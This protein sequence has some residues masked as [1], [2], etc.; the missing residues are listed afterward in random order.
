M[1][2]M[3]RVYTLREKS[4]LRTRLEER[5]QERER[6][7]RELHDTLLQSIQGMMLSFQA[8]AESLPGGSRARDSME[9]ALDRAEQVIAE[10]RDRIT[11][12]RGQMAPTEDLATA[13]QALKLEAGVPFSA[14]Y[15]VSNVGEPLVL[16]NDVR[17]AFYQVGKEA[18]FN[19]LR[20][21]EATDI[22]VTF[23]YKPDRFEMLVVDNGIGIDPL[24]QRMHGRPEHGGLRGMYERADRI[25]ASLTMVSTPQ[26]GTRITLTLPGS[27]AYINSVAGK[28][29]RSSKTG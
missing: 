4:I 2:W 27:A 23:T 9:R 6:I 24:Y 7:A 25:D 28:Q 18:V 10:G 1:V 3:S 16:L 26:E 5:F 21:A 22:T 17:D 19:S 12:L 13:F 15:Q 20:H 14:N 29:N 11:G 8:V